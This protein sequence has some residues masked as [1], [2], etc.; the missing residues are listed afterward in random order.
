MLSIEQGIKPPRLR[1]P[2]AVPDSVQSA[3][4]AYS[5]AC[6]KLYCRTP[7]LSYDK[8]ANKVCADG[9]WIVPKRLRELTAMM[10]RRIES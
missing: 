8:R 5:E 3:M 6:R 1:K 10:K 9:A 7:N 4:D 2:K